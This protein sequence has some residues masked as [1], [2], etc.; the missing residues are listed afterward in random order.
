M[1][2]QGALHLLHLIPVARLNHQPPY[3]RAKLGDDQLSVP[4]HQH[5]EDR[6]PPEPQQAADAFGYQYRL[7]PPQYLVT[8]LARVSAVLTG[9][10]QKIF[11]LQ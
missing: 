6:A 10:L 2:R 8:P 5:G 7:H 11:C 3:Q 9:V 4:F 1:F